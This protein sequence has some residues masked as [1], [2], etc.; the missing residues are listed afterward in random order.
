MK[1]RKQ[2]VILGGV[3]AAVALIIGTSWY[4]YKKNNDKIKNR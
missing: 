2:W 1:K 3:L 4:T